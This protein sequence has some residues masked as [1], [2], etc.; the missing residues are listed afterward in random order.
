MRPSP[1]L[2]P[3]SSVLWAPELGVAG[4]AAWE[5]QPKET[6]LHTVWAGH[7]RSRGLSSQPGISQA[8]NTCLSLFG[9]LERNTAD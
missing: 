4:A 6:L 8:G 5:M 2:L 3:S 7:G 1:F 9:L